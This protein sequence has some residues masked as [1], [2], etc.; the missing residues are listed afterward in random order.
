M[1][2]FNATYTKYYM[3]TDIAGEGEREGDGERE[4]ERSSLR[5]KGGEGVLQEHRY[6][7]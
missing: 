1:R 2:G 5:A 6:C 4:R 3:D 7:W